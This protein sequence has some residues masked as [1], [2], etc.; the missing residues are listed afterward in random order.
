M[1]EKSNIYQNMFTPENQQKNTIYL[2]ELI[3]K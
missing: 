3:L 2:S 1:T